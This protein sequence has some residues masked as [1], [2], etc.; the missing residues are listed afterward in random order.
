MLIDSIKNKNYSE[1][2]KI[3]AFWL[4]VSLFL[5]LVTL[6]SYVNIANPTH[7]EDSVYRI[8]TKKAAGTGTGT[9]FLVSGNDIVVTNEHVISGARAVEVRYVEN[10]EVISHSAKVI[11]KDK[12][13]DLA[14][15]KTV[16]GVRGAPLYLANIDEDQL[17]KGDN[18]TAIGF[19]AAADNLALYRNRWNRSGYGYQSII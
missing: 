16:R 3:P 1:V 18:V 4:G 10:E 9:G 6:I 17:R 11:W 2:I 19:P 5:L 8:V 12:K 14:I 7:L 15:L 13:Q